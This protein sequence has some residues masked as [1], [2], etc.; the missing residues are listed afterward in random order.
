MFERYGWRHDSMLRTIF[1][2][3]SNNH[4]LEIYVDLPTH[5]SGISTIDTNILVINLRH[6]LVILDKIGKSIILYKLSV[7]FDNTP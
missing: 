4:P 1:S 7:P 6:D 2:S 5:L 3:I